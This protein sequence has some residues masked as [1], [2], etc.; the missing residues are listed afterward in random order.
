MRKVL[1][2]SVALV[3]VGGV[4]AASAIDI[5]GSYEFNYINADNGTAKTGGNNNSSMASD[6]IV[7]FSG[8]QTSDAGL[9]FG[10]KMTLN[11]SGSIEDQGLTIEGDFGMIMAGQTDGVVDGMD[12]FMIQS[13]DYETG[14]ATGFS[15]A[16]AM[17]TGTAMSDNATQG[18][19]GYRSPNISGFQVGVSIEDAGTSSG[20]DVMSTMITYEM[21]GFKVGYGSLDAPSATDTGADT[22][23]SIYGIGYTAGDFNVRWSA[24]QQKISGAGGGADTSKQSSTEYGAQYSGL[25]NLTLYYSA[26]KTEEKLGNSAYTGDT[27]EGSAIGAWYTVAPGVTLTVEQT[28]AEYRDGTA[29]GSQNDKMDTTFIGLGVTF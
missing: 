18:K 25:E 15:A 21:D 9:T 22:T 17:R 16:N 19:V 13:V 5:S 10:G 20:A 8:S 27:L 14:F 1:L 4:S 6:G 26:A 29:G 12:N 11:H 2:T 7:S 24:G 23:Q 3:A 28:S